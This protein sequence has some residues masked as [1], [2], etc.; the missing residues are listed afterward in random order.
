[1]SRRCPFGRGA[2]GVWPQFVADTVDAIAAVP[3][4]IVDA[5]AE[6]VPLVRLSNRAS[7]RFMPLVVMAP[8]TSLPTQHK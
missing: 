6:D 3:D 7:T 2:A 4:R 8:G 1:M 5:E